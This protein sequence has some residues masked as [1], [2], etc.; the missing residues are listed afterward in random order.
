[1]DEYTIKTTKNNRASII[2]LIYRYGFITEL[3]DD[4]TFDFKFYDNECCE[5]ATD[6]LDKLGIDYTLL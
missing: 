6:E 3:W 1:M 5:D 4:N 2:K